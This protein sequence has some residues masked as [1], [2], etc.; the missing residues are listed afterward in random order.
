M[1]PIRST[2]ATA[3][4]LFLAGAAHAAPR[5]S[6]TQ[7][8][9][10]TLSDGRV[11]KVFTLSNARGMQARIT[12]YGGILVSLRVP[13]RRGRLNDVVLGYDNLASYL[14]A[15]PYF[16]ATIGRYGNRIAKGRFS[17]DG[18]TY[19]LA[20]NNA[21]NHL[22]GGNVGFDKRLWNAR[23][24]RVKKGVALELRYFSPSGEEGYP[25]NLQARVIYTLSEANT[26]RITYRAVTDRATP[27]NPTHHSYWNLSDGGKT[28]IVDQV[29][30]IRAHRYTPIDKTSI[31]SGELPLVVGTPFDF[32]RPRIIGTYL[33][34]KGAFQP[35]EQLHNGNGYDHNFVLDGPRGRVR[36][37]ARLYAPRSGRVMTVYT[38]QPGLQL[39]TGN[40]LDGTNIGKG[41]VAYR[42]RS[43]LCLE[44]QGFPDSPNHPNFPS[45]ILR[46]GQMYRQTTIYAFS[47]AR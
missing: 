8:T 1:N 17:L 47:T 45:T 15:S 21:P 42:F 23:P 4:A 34:P 13:D 27:F 12:N 35:N 19:Q 40:F 16:G 20:T 26:L 6:I 31:P 25:G 29:L 43:A 28:P 39:Y 11:A 30:Q 41:G 36:L 18:K 22:H 38:D 24:L 14:K 44:T 46:P 5:A 9:F 2:I 3:L 32:L 37:A 7:S 33:T 10:G